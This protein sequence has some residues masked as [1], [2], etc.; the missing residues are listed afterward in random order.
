LF[1][2]GSSAQRVN[3][4]LQNID[5]QSL[6]VLA[7]GVPNLQAVLAGRIQI[8]GGQI[9]GRILSPELQVEDKRLPLDLDF[10]GS[11][12]SVDVRGT[13]GRSRISS[14]ID[15]RHAEGL[16]VFDQFPLESTV[17]AAVGDTG[18]SG[19][20][21]GA[22]RFNVP[23]GNLRDTTLDFASE[24]IRLTQLG[25]SALQQE[26]RGQVNFRYEG[27][28]LFVDQA[29]FEGTG[30]WDASG[31]ISPEVLDF[32]LSARDADFTPILS[33]F[34]QLASIGLGASGSLEIS[35]QGSFAD[36]Q[37]NLISPTLNVAVGGSSYQL[38]GAR[39]NL[40]GTKLSTQAQL[41]GVSPVTGNLTLVGNGE[42]LL[43][44]I[45]P[46]LTL[47]ATGNASVPTLGTIN[48]LDAVITAAPETGW[49]L[50]A[51]GLLGNPFTLTGSLAPLDVRLQGTDLN[52]RAPENFLAS[53]DSTIDI[54]VRYEDGIVISGG[55]DASRVNLD[56]NR[57][58][59]DAASSAL[60]TPAVTSTPA[61]T[62]TDISPGNRFL[63]QVRFENIAIRAPQQI[64]FKENFGQAELGINVVLTGTAAEPELVGEAQSLRGN[65]R[66]AGRDFTIERAVATFQPSQGIYPTVDIR[67]YS[68]FDQEQV[69]GGLQNI[70]FVEPSGRTFQVFLNLKAELVEKPGGGFTANITER[71]LSS[72][73]RIEQ[74]SSDAVAGGQRELTQDE[75]ISLLTL[76]RLQLASSITGQDSVAES[77]AQGAVDTVI[78]LFIVSELQRQIGDALGL[79]L[80]E[81]ST[82]PLSSLFDG[83]EAFGV[84]LRIGGYLQDDLFA[85]YEIRTLDLDADVA[86]ANE[87]DLRYEFDR[88][89]VD[90]TGRLNFRSTSFRPIPELSVGVGYAITPLVRLE[91]NADLSQARQ[92]VGFGVSLRW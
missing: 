7:K 3:V 30:R 80:F 14:T 86:F 43:G 55:V 34:P 49:Q 19:Q 67:A 91:T 26:S 45:R 12:S 61:T 9:V 71:S 37:V 50:N 46:T 92:S 42:L 2:Q 84:A 53:S 5:V 22:A 27:G 48:S 29:F 6:P 87:F 76:K 23:W 56:L 20:L 24:Q 79:D 82:T 16:I 89:E 81:V 54:R 8:S 40:S 68:T 74:A 83:S 36:P 38:Q 85:S 17:E 39:L 25:E 60:E 78:D 59:A 10:N 66:F 65:F 63:E 52:L 72:D 62:T 57:E 75:L 69:L 28:A 41:Q 33:L 4:R 77:V 31:E 90:L 21:I 47:R 15:T 32:R 11:L 73:A 58:A 64:T 88:L 18:V 51:N 35:A 1:P 44:P 70:E 13:L